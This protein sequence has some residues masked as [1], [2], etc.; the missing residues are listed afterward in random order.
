MEIITDKLTGQTANIGTFD[1]VISMTLEGY[2]KSEGRHHIQCYACG[3]EI[4]GI[5]SVRI[6]IAKA[7]A[8]PFHPDCVIRVAPA[9]SRPI[10]NPTDDPEPHLDFNGAA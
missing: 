9:E 4:D 6:G 8:V 5:E 7:I 2:R 3:F 10:V 1:S